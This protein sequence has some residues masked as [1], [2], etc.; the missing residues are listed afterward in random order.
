MTVEWVRC[1]C[2]CRFP[3]PRGEL[4][5]RCL[6]CVVASR[7]LASGIAADDPGLA[8]VREWNAAAYA[9]AQARAA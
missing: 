1:A 4:Y 9:A 8:T 5:D 3:R 2:G 7:L 6:T